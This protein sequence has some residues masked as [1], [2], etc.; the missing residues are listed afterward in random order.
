[1]VVEEDNMHY[2]PF[3]TLPALPMQAIKLA[4]G[5]NEA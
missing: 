5:D 1:M 2:T 4:S 3:A